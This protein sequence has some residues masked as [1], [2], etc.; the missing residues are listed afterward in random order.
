MLPPPL[1][2]NSCH[3]LHDLPSNTSDHCSLFAEICSKIFC[4]LQQQKKNK[5]SLYNWRKLS[6]KEISESYSVTQCR[7]LN[8]PTSPANP[9]AI[10]KCLL[11]ICT[12][13]HNSC[14][15]TIPPKLFQKYKSQARTLQSMLLID[16]PKLLGSGGSYLIIQTNLLVQLENHT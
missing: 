12:A 1:F 16:G 11:N 9:S 4:C 10:E 3:V 8:P 6:Q 15:E 5:H 7:E 14:K 2:F 13:M